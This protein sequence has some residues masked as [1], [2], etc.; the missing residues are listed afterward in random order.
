MKI[1]VSTE[2]E[3]NLVGSKY[4]IITSREELDNVLKLYR[5]L[6]SSINLA[7]E[8]SKSI[9][10]AIYNVDILA[11][12][13]QQ[14]ERFH[15]ALSEIMAYYVGLQAEIFFTIRLKKLED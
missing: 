1:T 8:E 10:S 7:Y 2:H 9:E 3:V 11:P 15:S 14:L 12:I 13:I 4:S 6:Q 5:I